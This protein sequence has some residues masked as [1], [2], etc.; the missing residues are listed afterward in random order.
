MTVPAATSAEAQPMT[1][2]EMAEQAERSIA[3]GDFA[4]AIVLY[5]RVVRDNPDNAMAW[6]RL[7]VAYLRSNQPRQGQ[8]ALE[9]AISIDPEM[10]KAYANL[11]MAYL[12]QF[13]TAAVQAI[14]SEEI[15]DANRNALRLLLRD[16][17]DALYP[18]GAV[19][20]SA[21]Q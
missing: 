14:P 9:H 3:G 21:V 18:S 12:L 20:L 16:V 6:S 19:S 13:R 10:K 5:E 4:A 17:N 8:W 2:V 11:A 7:G 1:H 15:S